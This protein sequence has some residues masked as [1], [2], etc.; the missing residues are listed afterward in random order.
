MQRI[1]RVNR[2]GSTA[3]EVHVFNFYPTAKVNNDIE[4][5]KKAI[6]KLQSFHAALGEDSQIYSPDEETETFGLFDKEM[7]E[8]KDEKLAY[9]MMIRDIKEKSPGLFKQ[10]KNMP[11]RARV[12]RKNK[13]LNQGTICYIKDSKRDAFILVKENGDQSA[14]QAETEEL[15]FLE[16]VKIFEAE[17]LEKAIPLH[18]KHHEQVQA[19]ILLFS[20]LLEKEKAKDK[21]I[22]TTQGPNEKKANAYL[23]AMLNLPLVNEE[24]RALIIKAKEAL[25][26]GRFQNLQRDIN[27]FQRTLK[28]FPLKPAIILEKVIEIL[29]GYPLMNEEAEQEFEKKIVRVKTLNPE[30]IITESFSQ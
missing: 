27:K 17:V 16:T 29:K 8:E 25:R 23:D 2:I 6:M 13:D 22:D 21:K 4:L 10:I 24:E 9:L 26:Q 28:K 19:G 1:G 30:I 12:G 15:T 20:D 11:F 18:S 14:E 3:D 5:E 7:E